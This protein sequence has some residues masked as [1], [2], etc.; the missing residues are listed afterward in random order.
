MLYDF[1]GVKVEVRETEKPKDMEEAMGYFIEYDDG[2]VLEW[3]DDIEEFK[4]CEHCDEPWYVHEGFSDFYYTE[5]TA[6]GLDF[7]YTMTEEELAGRY[8]DWV[9]LV[10]PVCAKKFKEMGLEEI[11]WW[12]R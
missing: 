8:A 2:I 11:T 1:G 7:T 5:A 6:A 9:V 12:E 3:T 4:F 10:C